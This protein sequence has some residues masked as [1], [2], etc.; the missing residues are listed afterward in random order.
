MSTEFEAHYSTAFC[1][2][3]KRILTTKIFYICIAIKISSLSFS[4]LSLGFI[5]EAISVDDVVGGAI[6]LIA[7]LS[8]E[9]NIYDKI[10]N[11]QSEAKEV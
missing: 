10:M 11:Q 6:I 9:F 2:V 4:S 8:N 5:G 3:T 1:E 7:C